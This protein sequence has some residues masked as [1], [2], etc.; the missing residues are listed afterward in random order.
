MHNLGLEFDELTVS[1]VVYGGRQ[2]G[3]VSVREGLLG[4]QPLR[5]LGLK[6]TVG[7]ALGQRDLRWDWRSRL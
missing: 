1:Q 5:C 7:E 6:E 2:F 3:E 4:T